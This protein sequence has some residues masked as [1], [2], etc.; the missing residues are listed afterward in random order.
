MEIIKQR[1]EI[2]FYDDNEENK[3]SLWDENL[4]Y[5]LLWGQKSKLWEKCQ[6]NEI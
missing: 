3:V 4:N 6:Y 1:D 2:M 5:E